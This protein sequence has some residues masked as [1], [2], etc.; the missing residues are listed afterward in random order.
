MV[1]VTQR[2]I[3]TILVVAITDLQT[4]N[5]VAGE[6][7]LKNVT[8]EPS[9]IQTEIKSTDGPEQVNSTSETKWANSTSKLVNVTDAQRNAA[10]I[11]G[12]DEPSFRNLTGESNMKSGIGE[13]SMKNS[14]REQ[15]LVN[16]T[17]ERTPVNATGERTPVNATGERTPVNATGERTSVNATGERTSVNTTGESPPTSPTQ[18]KEWTRLI[19]DLNTYVRRCSTVRPDE[20]EGCE[21]STVR[22]NQMLDKYEGKSKIVLS[23]VDN[24]QRLEWMETCCYGA[25]RTLAKIQ[26]YRKKHNDTELAV[27]I[28]IFVKVVYKKKN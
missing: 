28:K 11:K 16:V 4:L 25:H 5:L 17:G 26:E 21:E 10:L 2:W 14:I 15:A 23:P 22:Y 6:S 13:R 8:G 9:A 24:K 12:A 7:S 27:D 18:D 3:V 1:S 19:R 20:V